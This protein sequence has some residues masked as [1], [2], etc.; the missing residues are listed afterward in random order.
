MGEYVNDGLYDGAKCVKYLLWPNCNGTNPISERWIVYD[1]ETYTN[2]YIMY[3]DR[4]KCI[5]APW[6][7]FRIVNISF[8]SWDIII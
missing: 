8:R 5:S 7:C 2:L 3:P 6:D 4:K 1:P